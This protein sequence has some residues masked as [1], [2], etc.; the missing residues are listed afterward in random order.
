MS[1]NQSQWNTVEDKVRQKPPCPALT[2]WL[3]CPSLMETLFASG[4]VSGLLRSRILAWKVLF[5]EFEKTCSIVSLWLLLLR[6]L[7]LFQFLSIHVTCIFLWK[8][9]SSSLYSWWH[10]TMIC[11]IFSS[12]LGTGKVLWM[13]KPVFSNFKKL[14]S[15]VSL[16]NNF[17]LF[18]LGI[19]FI[20]CWAIC[21]ALQYVIS[22]FIQ[23]F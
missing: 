21:M 17:P 11:L 22:L 8:L 6:P 23:L 10:F 15:V 4:L 14:S 3:L 1:Q 2:S 7:T 18:S 5:S 9:L 19:L 12:L 13:R 16:I 20:W